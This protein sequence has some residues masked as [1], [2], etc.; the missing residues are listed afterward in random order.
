MT[1]RIGTAM[2]AIRFALE[3]PRFQASVFHGPDFLREWL[4]GAI[5]GQDSY[6]EFDDFT[7]FIAANPDNEVSVPVDLLYRLADATMRAIVWNDTEPKSLLLALDREAYSAVK[8]ILNKRRAQL[9]EDV[10]TMN[11]GEK[12]AGEL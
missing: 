11:A 10:T 9:V 7:K 6:G 4:A 8:A 12:K 5:N 2:Q 3:H 1:E